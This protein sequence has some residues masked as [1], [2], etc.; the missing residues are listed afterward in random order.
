M[1]ACTVLAALG[2]LALTLQDDAGYALRSRCD[3]V[4]EGRSPFEVVH[5]DGATDQF[6]VNA[7]SAVTVLSEAVT[8]AKSAGFPWNDKPIRLLPQKRLV[9][10]LALSRAKGLAGESEA[11]DE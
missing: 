4:C 1:S 11:E 3:L 10:L 7:E 8:A 6:E 5:P 9:E 2:L